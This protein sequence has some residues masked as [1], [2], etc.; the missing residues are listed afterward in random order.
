MLRYKNKSLNAEM[1]TNM[2]VLHGKVRR[3]RFRARNPLNLTKVG[4][5]KR[6]VGVANLKV[7]GVAAPPTV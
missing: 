2:T 1:S 4:V 7:G 3:Y 6:K 5:A